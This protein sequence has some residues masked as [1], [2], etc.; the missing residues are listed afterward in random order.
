MHVTKQHKPNRFDLLTL[1]RKTA[2]DE[3]YEQVPKPPRSIPVNAPPN[4]RQLSLDNKLPLLSL[5]KGLLTFSR[6][7]LGN[8][9]Y[10][11]NVTEFDLADPNCFTV[12]HEYVQLHD[13][14]T[15]QCYK[16]PSTRKRLREI[17]LIDDKGEV[18]CSLRKFNEFR[19]YLKKAY[20]SKVNHLLA[21]KAERDIDQRNLLFASRIT[22]K[23]LEQLRKQAERAE[24]RSKYQMTIKKKDEERLEKGQAALERFEKNIE[25]YEQMMD[26]RQYFLNE[27]GFRRQQLTEDHNEKILNAM[28]MR[29][30]LLKKK[31]A[32][33]N[34]TIR[35]RKVLHRLQ[36][37][38][39]R[40]ME[41]EQKW[42]DRML[43]QKKKL[44]YDD[45]ILKRFEEKTQ[46]NIMKRQK[47]IEK[48][49]R[50]DETKRMELKK[51]AGLRKQSRKRKM[52]EEK[53]E[54][55]L[56]MFY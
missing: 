48:R 22:Q 30:I 1:R 26:E 9:L 44:D 32:N 27:R 39:K 35:Q 3:I 37:E 54:E 50:R 6:N 16:N 38:K 17:G 31:I 25:R 13:P 28:K 36:A 51:N 5:P 29:I 19:R 18:V 52:N 23:H 41:I 53:D 15:R 45:E 40:A 12:S 55:S 14:H 24:I 34:E 42:I 4:W 49:R 21:I 10:G 47:S 7:K 8:K 2:I 43:W 11:A 20:L 46:L 33:E 56:Q